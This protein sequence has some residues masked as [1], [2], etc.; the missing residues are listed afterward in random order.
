[1]LLL[2]YAKLILFRYCCYVN[3]KHYS[4]LHLKRSYYIYIREYVY[5]QDE[6]IHR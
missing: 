2:L 4:H 1:M 3:T 6:S 5:M